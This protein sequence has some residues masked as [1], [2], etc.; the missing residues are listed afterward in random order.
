MNQERKGLKSTKP[1]APATFQTYQQTIMKNVANLQ[2]QQAL[3]YQSLDDIILQHLQTGT[4]P[5]LAA[6]NIERNEVVCILVEVTPPNK[7]YTDLTGCFHY[8]SSR[9]IHGNYPKNCNIVC[10][11][12]SKSLNGGVLRRNLREVRRPKYIQIVEYF[13]TLNQPIHKIKTIVSIVI[14]QILR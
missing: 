1:K 12:Q 3:P 14:T 2:K 6:P 9:G 11:P 8:K 13:H 4:F 7:S 10:L 5:S